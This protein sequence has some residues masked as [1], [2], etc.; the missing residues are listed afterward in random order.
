M[1]KARL[2]T[3][4][5]YI[6]KRLIKVWQ[7]SEE[8]FVKAV[9]EVQSRNKKFSVD[10]EIFQAP[11]VGGR[12]EGVVV[13]KETYTLTQTKAYN[14]SVIRFYSNLVRGQQ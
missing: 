10:L 1:Y 14:S 11:A 13:V 2:L 8:E 12:R 9:E 5:I 7:D 6:F 4:L 3:S